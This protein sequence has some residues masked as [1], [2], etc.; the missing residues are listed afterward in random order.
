[1]GSPLELTTLLGPRRVDSGVVLLI[2]VVEKCTDVNGPRRVPRQRQR[3]RG[4]LSVMVIQDHSPH[5][6]V[7]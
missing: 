2:V 3:T 5:V 7:M 6:Q 1:M 4:A